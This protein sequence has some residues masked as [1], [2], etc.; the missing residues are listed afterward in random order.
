MR[1]MAALPS[2]RLDLRPLGETDAPFV[3]SLCAN[4][5]VTRTLLRIQGP[6]SSQQALEL[7]EAQSASSG[8]HRFIAALR[9]GARP[10]GLGN[11]RLHTGAKRVATIGYSVLP[12]FWGQGL[13]TELG[14]LLVEV[15]FGALGALEARA[16]TLVENPAS[17]RIREKI[18][19]AVRD[20]GAIEVDS[21]GSQRRV[22]RWILSRPA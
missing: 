20:T 16:T 1:R 19:F 4:S 8:E 11:V 21:R 13:A 10:G 14:R 12:A 5:H 18:G 22:T 6:L 7:C 15:G 3:E 9:V 17:G 2:D